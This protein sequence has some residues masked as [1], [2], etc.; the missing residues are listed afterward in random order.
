MRQNYECSKEDHRKKL[1]MDNSFVLLH[2]QSV[3]TAIYFSTN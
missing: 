1:T 3:P 2:S